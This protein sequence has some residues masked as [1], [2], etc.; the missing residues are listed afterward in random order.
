[1]SANSPVI[2]P[3]APVRQTYA[4]I[5]LNS[6]RHVSTLHDTYD[7]KA[8][9]LPC[10]RLVFLCPGFASISGTTSAKVRWTCPPQYMLW[11]RPW[12]RVAPVAFVVTSVS[13]RAVRHARHAST[14][15]VTTFPYAEM[16]GLSSLTCRDET[17][18][19]KWNFGFTDSTVQGTS[20]CVLTRGER[21]RLRMRVRYG[22]A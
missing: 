7:E 20:S 18:R 14:R 13:H 1:M 4:R 2:F 11:R 12:T 3:T 8:V 21:C 16:H 17:W 6:S 15:H 10:T 19:V 5:P 22:V 9:V